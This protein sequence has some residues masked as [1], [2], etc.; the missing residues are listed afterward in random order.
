MLDTSDIDP[1]FPLPPPPLTKTVARESKIS[2]QFTK[3]IYATFCVKQTTSA[4]QIKMN[5]PSASANLIG[6]KTT[7]D[8]SSETSTFSDE[9][10][11]LFF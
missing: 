2:D 10:V 6:L 1:P 5:E 8:I 3:S 11:R 7:S 9:P 4:L